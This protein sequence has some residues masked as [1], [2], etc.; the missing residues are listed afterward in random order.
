M[1]DPLVLCFDMRPS[2]RWN[3][4]M[5]RMHN[6]VKSLSFHLWPRSVLYL[7]RFTNVSDLLTLLGFNGTLGGPSAVL[8]RGG[9]NNG[10]AFLASRELRGL[11]V[12]AVVCILVDALAESSESQ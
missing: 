7:L 8:R 3:G 1:C 9:C 2:D 11:T 12:R 10:L 4:Y 5:L 6:H